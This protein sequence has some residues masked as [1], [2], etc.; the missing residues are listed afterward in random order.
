M[1]N[2]AT[3]GQIVDSSLQ[4][5]KTTPT[6]F[7]FIDRIGTLFGK[8]GQNDAS[9]KE[10]K[11]ETWDFSKFQ[12]SKWQLPKSK[13]VILVDLACVHEASSKLISKITEFAVAI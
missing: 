10:Q 8:V 11:E 2:W 7:H 13:E 12:S 9:L 1:R 5:T 4:S 3:S 6:N